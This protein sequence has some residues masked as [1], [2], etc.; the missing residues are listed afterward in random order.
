[1]NNTQKIRESI[2]FKFLT[3]EAFSKIIHQSTNENIKKNK[4][5]YNEYEISNDLY[6]VING[7]VGIY[8]ENLDGTYTFIKKI[9]EGNY[10]GEISFI[11]DHPREYTAKAEDNVSLFKISKKSFVSIYKEIKFDTFMQISAFLTHQLRLSF[12]SEIVQQSRISKEST[13]LKFY[14][15]YKENRVKNFWEISQDRLS[16]EL[17]ISRTTLVKIINI[18]EKENVLKKVRG[19]LL[20]KDIEFEEWRRKNE[21]DL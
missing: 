11:D 6:F 18:L 8:K 13:Y 2:F 19:G 15:L 17:K 20:I 10:F 9:T 12:Q 14:K 7:V 1:M 4:Y 3:D 16:K 5:V 21:S